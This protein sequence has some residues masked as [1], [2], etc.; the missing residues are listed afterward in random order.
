MMS[1]RSSSSSSHNWSQERTPHCVPAG[2]KVNPPAAALIVRQSS[3][4]LLAAAEVGKVV[5]SDP[6]RSR[7]APTPKLVDHSCA[8]DIH[9]QIFCQG[10]HPV[11]DEPL[12]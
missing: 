9:G 3:P 1:S 5:V 4:L 6:H 12:S 10:G 11:R 7:S 2:K 8:F